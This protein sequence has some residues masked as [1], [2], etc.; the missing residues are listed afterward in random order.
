M[1]LV[2]EY[3][4]IRESIGAGASLKHWDNAPVHSMKMVQEYFQIREFIGAGASIKHNAPVH[5]T[6]LVQEFF[7]I[8]ESMGWSIP[9]HW[10]NAPVHSIQLLHRSTSRSGSLGAGAS[11]KHWDND[12]VHSMKLVQEY[13]KVRESRCWVSL[14][15]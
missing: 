10:D 12:P 1:Q 15:H 8:R 9:D 2:Q 4:K 3:F 11:L 14:K 5:S 13:C 6:Q 7:Q